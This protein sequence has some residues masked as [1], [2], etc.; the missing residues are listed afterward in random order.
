MKANGARIAEGR[1]ERTVPIQFG[2]FEGLDVGMD[3]GSAV[4]FTYS[5]PFAFTGTVERVE[6]EVFPEAP[7]KQKAAEA[8]SQESMARQ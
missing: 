8:K 5:L 7:A 2:S 4:D 6:V 1:L 3:T